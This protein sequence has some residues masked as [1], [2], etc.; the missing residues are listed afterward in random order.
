M[1]PIMIFFDEGHFNCDVGM[2]KF[3]FYLKLEKCKKSEIS[4]WDRP[5]NVTIY[6]MNHEW[7]FL[8]EEFLKKHLGLNL[9]K[10]NLDAHFHVGVFRATWILNMILFLCLIPGFLN[11]NG[12][13]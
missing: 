2:K 8:F 7:R 9:E 4:R 10:K 6:I 12:D 11:D 3:F 13:L 1:E 5:S